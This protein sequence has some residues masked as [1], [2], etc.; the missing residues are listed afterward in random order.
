MHFYLVVVSLIL[1]RES[2]NCPLAAFD[3]AFVWAKSRVHTTIVSLEVVGAR[4]L[5]VAPVVSANE[6]LYTNVRFTEGVPGLW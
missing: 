4:H 6:F 1:S 3:P 2:V 5:F